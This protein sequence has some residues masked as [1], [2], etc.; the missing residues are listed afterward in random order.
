MAETFNT[1]LDK[2]DKQTKSLNGYFVRFKNRNTLDCRKSNLE[3]I[4]PRDAMLNI[5]TMRVD[6]DFDLTKDE[7]RFV[8]LNSDV[9]ADYYRDR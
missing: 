9:I 7:I 6:W 1:I 8:Y 2:W 5:K 3:L 4:H